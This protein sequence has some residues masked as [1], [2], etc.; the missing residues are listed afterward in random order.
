MA[1]D[2]QPLLAD[3]RNT[4][5]LKDEECLTKNLAEATEELRYTF[6]TLLQHNLRMSIW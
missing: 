2:I 4:S 3:V 6:Q 5:L 1:E